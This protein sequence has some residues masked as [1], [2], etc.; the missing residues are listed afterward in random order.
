M[1]GPRA[2]SSSTG[3]S[4][5]SSDGSDSAWSIDIHPPGSRAQWFALSRVG[6]I[7][8]RFSNCVGHFHARSQVSGWAAVFMAAVET[9]C[10]GVVRRL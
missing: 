7:A 3:I 9:P 4:G 1:T 8:L 10:G 6:S 2:V 5:A